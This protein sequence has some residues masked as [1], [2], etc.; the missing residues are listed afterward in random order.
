MIHEG[1]RRASALASHESKPQQENAAIEGA[2][3]TLSK[4]GEVASPVEKTLESNRSRGSPEETLT[5]GVEQEK[6]RLEQGLP[7]A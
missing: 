6:R 5:A 3:Q 7:S 2:T 1:K 4:E